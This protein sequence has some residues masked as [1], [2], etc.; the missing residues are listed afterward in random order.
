MTSIALSDLA[1]LQAVM[2]GQVLGPGASEFDQ[3]RR[4]W[5]GVPSTGSR[6]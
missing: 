2:T 6:R 1:S 5:N 3:A 4:V